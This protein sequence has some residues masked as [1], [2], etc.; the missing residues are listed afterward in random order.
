[1]IGM[2]LL[3]YFSTPIDA[4]VLP[5]HFPFTLLELKVVVLSEEM[6]GGCLKDYPELAG[7]T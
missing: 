1:M 2:L 7:V 4:R 5:L 3:R 6:A